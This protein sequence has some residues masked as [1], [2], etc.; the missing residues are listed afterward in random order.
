MENSRVTITKN[1]ITTLA[2][3]GKYC[4]AN[5]DVVVSVSGIETEQLLTQQAI[6]DALV[7]CTMQHYANDR[8]TKIGEHAF[9][10]QSALVSISCSS[11]RWA[12]L[13][14]FYGCDGLEQVD[15]PALEYVGDR[16]F[17]ECQKI[18]TLDLPS[19][20]VID[21]E[22]FKGC[23]KLSCLILR[24][25]EVCILSHD[26]AFED[27]PISYGRGVIYVPDALVEQYEAAE[28]WSAYI[29]S[30]LPISVLEHSGW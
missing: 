14:A 12:Y 16:A 24:G 20:K 23:T 1:G 19:L 10:Q 30:I 21:I 26:S 25:E 29:G 2:T 27:T 17:A 22:A 11:V 6:E 18:T 13:W 28:N 9:Q 5:V 8:I 15:M 7:Q 3:A 4:P